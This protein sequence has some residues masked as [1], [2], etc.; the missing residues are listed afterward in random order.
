MD[1]HHLLL[2]AMCLTGV[3][4]CLAV[5]QRDPNT[6]GRRT[7][8]LT[9][10]A[11]LAWCIGDLA[12]LRSWL[13]LEAASRL[14]KLGALAL[15]P[16]WLGVAVQTARLPLAR[17]VPWFPVPLA[18]P[19]ACVIALLFSSRWRGLYSMNGADGTVSEGP[20]FEVMMGYNFALAAAAC[21]I[22]IAAAF[23]WR[24]KGEEARRFAIGIAPFLTIGGS[25]LYYTGHWSVDHDPTPLLMGATLLVLHHGIFAGGLLQPLSVSQ[26]SLI[27]QLPLGVILTD[28]TGVVVDVNPV[29]ERR[30]GMAASA[31]LGR[32]FEAV[33]FAADADLRFEI[34]TVMAAGAE[35]GQIVLLDPPA[36]EDAP[37]ESLRLEVPSSDD[38]EVTG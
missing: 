28:R 18:A 34:S 35:A 5:W 25:A 11:W 19:A 9:T 21:C 8:V 13:P 37:R 7:F 31:A 1:L 20:L 16:L 15:P 32:N 10:L 17:R 12:M 33:L 3:W 2:E 14:M 36:K 6:P 29:A 27:Q 4:L 26:H 30:L 38:S 22:F 24:R 23:R